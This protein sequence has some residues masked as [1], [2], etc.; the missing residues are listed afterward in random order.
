[1]PASMANQT[2]YHLNVPVRDSHSAVTHEL[3]YSECRGS[4][5]D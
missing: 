2:K 4:E 5:F 3:H 1:M